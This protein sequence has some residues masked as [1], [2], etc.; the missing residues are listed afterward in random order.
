ML[1]LSLIIVFGVMAVDIAREVKRESAIFLEFARSRSLA[2]VVLLFPL[3]PIVYL[4]TGYTLGSGNTLGWLTAVVATAAC[5][6]PG[7]VV[8]RRV[9]F[10]FKRAGTDRVKAAQNAATRAFGAAIA[11]L[12]YAAVR[13]TLTFV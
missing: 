1:E 2:L 3:G 7:L 10:V 4:V 11:G 13:L 8:A 12:V 9:L 5:Y 6:L